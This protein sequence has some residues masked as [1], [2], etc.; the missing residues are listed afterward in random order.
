MGDCLSVQVVCT[1]VNLAWPSL[2][3]RRSE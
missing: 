1:W 3:G 2:Q